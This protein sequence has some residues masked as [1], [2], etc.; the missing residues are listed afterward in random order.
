MPHNDN[1]KCACEQFLDTV[2]ALLLIYILF[3]TIHFIV[4]KL[5]QFFR[6]LG[7][8]LRKAKTS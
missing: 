7:K 5:I 3:V 2:R 6:W 8:K 1:R 4:K